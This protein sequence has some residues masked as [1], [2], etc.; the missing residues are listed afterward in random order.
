MRKILSM[1]LIVIAMFAL[2]GCGSISKTRL[3]AS[4]VETN[5]AIGDVE[6]RLELTY[7][8][9]VLSMAVE[10]KKFKDRQYAEEYEELLNTFWGKQ[11]WL[12]IKRLSE[13][14]TTTFKGIPSSYEYAGMSRATTRATLEADGWTIE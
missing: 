10:T 2:V 13:T 6:T 1:A 8:N 14:V 7:S 3:T 5:A 12:E 4:I 11:E 9:D